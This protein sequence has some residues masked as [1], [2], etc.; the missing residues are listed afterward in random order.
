MFGRGFVLNAWWNSQ[1]TSFLCH[2]MQGKFVFPDDLTDPI[3]GAKFV[4]DLYELSGDTLHKYSVPVRPPTHPAAT[5]HLQRQLRL[6]RRP[7]VWS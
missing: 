2:G 6:Q 1:T 3:N 5:C 7:L 4:R